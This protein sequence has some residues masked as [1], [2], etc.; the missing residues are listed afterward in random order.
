MIRSIDHVA[1]T[2]TQLFFQLQSLGY[3]RQTLNLIRQ[4]YECALV[5]FN[6]HYRGSGKPFVC[7]LIGVASVL[8]SLGLS[9]EYVIAGLLHATY[10]SQHELE[11]RL[12]RKYIRKTFGEKVDELIFSYTKFAWDK[13]SILHT[14]SK[15]WNTL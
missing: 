2:N 14:L 4:A 12:I 6:S 9:S 5:L 7:H 15:Y 1:Q 8:A 11:S 3:D 13:N 10:E